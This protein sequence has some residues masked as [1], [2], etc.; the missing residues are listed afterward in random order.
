ML[1]LALAAA[2]IALLAA[3][4]AVERYELATYIS[5]DVFGGRARSPPCAHHVATASAIPACGSIRLFFAASPTRH[6]CISS[7][8]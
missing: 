2:C 7:A 6:A 3:V 1:R 4:V 5:S 8:G